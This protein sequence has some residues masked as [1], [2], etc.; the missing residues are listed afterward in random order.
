M[1]E[2]TLEMIWAKTNPFQS[3]KTHAVVTGVV[4]Q[5]VLSEYLSK[6]LLQLLCGCLNLDIT[7]TICLVGYLASLH[8][9]GK[10]EPCFQAKEE[11]T[12]E[13]L[14]EKGLLKNMLLSP[15]IRHEETTRY[16]L[17]EIWED[18]T[19]KTEIAELYADILASHHQGK[20]GEG[21]KKT[22]EPWFSLENEL[23][24]EMRDRFLTKEKQI[25]SEDI[26]FE[27]QSELSTILLGIVILS[28]WIASG[29]FFSDAEDWIRSDY[30]EKTIR[31]KTNRFLQISGLAHQKID[32]GKNFCDVWP[33]FASDR[34]RALQEKT[35]QLFLQTDARVSAVLIEA[36][37]GEGKTEAGLYAAIQMAQQWG[38]DGFYV[39]LPTAAT[40]NQMVGRMQQLLT[41]HHCGD[42]IKLLH[43]MAWLTEE[44]MQQLDFTDDLAEIR[45]WLQP[46]KRGLL[47]PYAVGTVDQAMMAVCNV[48][49]GVLRLLGLSQKV[50]II[51]EIHSYDVYMSR[52]I[53][54]L[55]KWCKALQIPV[56][57][58]SA[59]LPPD[60]KKELLAPYTSEKLPAAYPA[61]TAVTESGIP[62][63]MEIPSTAQ[64]KTVSI[65]IALH[66]H[67]PKQI[68][69][70]ADDLTKNGG[71]ICVLLN[72]V[73][74][75]QDV[76]RAL[77]ENQSGA[78]LLLFHARFPAKRRSEIEKECV[79]LFGK[80]K[81]HRPTRA[82]LVATQ[83]VEQSLDVDFDAM[84]SA[85]A[86]VDLVL[87]R[88]GR[89]HRH[90]ETQRPDSLR[91]PKMILLAPE[92]QWEADKAIYP[93]CLL[94]QSYHLFCQK[95]VVRIPEDMQSFVTDGYD[96]RKAPAEELEKGMENMVKDQISAVA[97]NVYQINEPDG[98]VYSGVCRSRRSGN[99]FGEEENNG[100]LT[101]KTRLSEPTV[102]LALLEDTLFFAY[103]MQ[104]D[105][106]RL[107]GEM[108]KQVMEQTVSISQK[109][110]YGKE[111]DLLDTKYDKTLH[112]M[113]LHIRNGCVQLP[114][115][116]TLVYDSAIGVQIVKDGDY[117]KISL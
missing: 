9:I 84:I 38:K 94:N 40:S 106:G 60:K 72:T 82:I 110:L 113:V 34:L 89:I 79:R 39:A 57:L 53:H 111:T 70:M 97:G 78:R 114:N 23:E 92:K 69:K 16:I 55:I 63:T 61:I 10:I 96:M 95:Q 14:E 26:Q 49:Y 112:V 85:F 44:T 21:K 2:I 27:R 47:A 77:E 117:G 65:E 25:F 3:I 59:T 5:T 64:R 52:F 99:F 90:A 12:R 104:A 32:W 24:E 56:V 71:C 108:M 102:T 28:D 45:R 88:M 86:P 75:A 67:E 100:F 50:L 31:E 58:L 4:A 76:Y 13:M 87:Q 20:N 103:R 107:S 68:A 66:L 101:A 15:K 48:K 115:N 22:K 46:K 105:S 41:M 73:D 83:V 116:Q 17:T 30:A 109:K 80:D 93:E 33:N 81:T 7:N 19:D 1:K 51:D 42:R 37:M 29:S 43:S 74:Q 8:D 36:P 35:Q 54:L 91:D 11:R 62:I 98:R 6:G 18:Y